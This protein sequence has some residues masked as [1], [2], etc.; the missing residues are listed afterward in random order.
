MVKKQ[1]LIYA[2]IILILI[3][4]LSFSQSISC[5]FADYDNENREDTMRA[6][7][8]IHVNTP[9]L[10]QRLQNANITTYYYLVYHANSDWDDFKNEF[11]PAA[12]DAGIKVWV[13]LV[14]PSED[15]PSFPF[16]VASGYTLQTGYIEWAK[17][18]AEQANL[19]SNLMGFMMD[20][21]EH[22]TANNNLTA[23]FT[24]KFVQQMMQEAHNI[25]PRLKFYVVN[26]YRT[27]LNWDRTF[28]SQWVDLYKNV[29]DGAIFPYL[30][31]DNTASLDEQIKTVKTTLDDTIKNGYKISFPGN[32]S[33][34][35][36]EYGRITQTINVQSA[37][38]YSL[39]LTQ[40]DD[41]VATSTGPHLKRILIDG[42]VV[43]SQNVFGTAST[44]VTI[45]LTSALLGKT[46]ATIAYEIYESQTVSND[47]INWFFG[48]L[49]PTN[50]TIDGTSTQ[51]STNNSNFEFSLTPST[52]INN[53]P[54]I[55]MIY[56]YRT[57]FHAAFPTPSYISSALTI[58]HQS[59]LDGIS[60]GL[61][62]YAL[63]KDSVTHVDY[64]VVKDLYTQWVTDCQATYMSPLA[65]NIEQSY[66]LYPNPVEQELNILGLSSLKNPKLS[67]QDAS[68]RTYPMTTYSNRIN[69]AHLAPGMYFLSILSDHQVVSVEKIIKL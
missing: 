19:Y 56:A 38:S 23:P 1:S 14:P 47:S 40:R 63:R 50:F 51:S 59:V 13:Y 61:V 46:T 28:S 16:D 29:I 68:G 20:D 17:A 57:S 30:D 4:T 69:L 34:S 33:S 31:L 27:Y 9:V 32:T 12:Q 44:K 49:L 21:F 41:Y 42:V 5:H 11:M 55:V 64:V 3:P 37:S 65:G 2:F 22:P 45:N 24:P 26:Y 53:L 8:I 62:T 25:C 15:G 48:N 58:A 60:E 36:A 7:G 43:W 54:L 66:K 52:Y 67:I 18:I 39:S 35:V 6:D 10:I